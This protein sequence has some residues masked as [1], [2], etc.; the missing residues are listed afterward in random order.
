[1]IT[2]PNKSSSIDEDQLGQRPK[3]IAAL[4]LAK[5]VNQERKYELRIDDQ[6]R[7]MVTKKNFNRAYAEKWK[8]NHEN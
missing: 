3:A 2:N 8:A 5:R 7:I 1:M 6:T 4:A